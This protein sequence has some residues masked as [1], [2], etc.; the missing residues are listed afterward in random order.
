MSLVAVSLVAVT[1]V[2]VTLVATTLVAVTLVSSR[3][4][5]GSPVFWFSGVK[6]WTVSPSPC[7]HF[8]VDCDS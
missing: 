6:C 7:C 5:G 2:A 4:C 3:V 1:L 8:V